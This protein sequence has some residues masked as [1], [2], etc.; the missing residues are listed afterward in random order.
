MI[1]NSINELLESYNSKIANLNKEL[2]I[3][4]CFIRLNKDVHFTCLNKVL[5][6]I[7]FNHSFKIIIFERR[8]RPFHLEPCDV[9]IRT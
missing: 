7:N 2:K 8:N 6:K 9:Q 3:K 1:I 4:F 5:L